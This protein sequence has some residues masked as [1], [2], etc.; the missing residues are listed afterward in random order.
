[1]LDQPQIDQLKVKHGSDLVLVTSPD[2][3]ELVF[4]KPTRAE[5]DAWY[6]KRDRATTAGRMLAQS[7][8]VYPDIPGL[9][10]ALDRQPALLMCAK[11]IVDS[12]TDLAGAE[13]GTTQSKKI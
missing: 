4:R 11:G 9:M 3:T 8:I 7:C 13:V 6:D 10:E 12:I 1:M 2:G 5:Y